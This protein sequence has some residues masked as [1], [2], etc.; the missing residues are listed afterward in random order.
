MQQF[1]RERSAIEKEYSSKLTAL[2]RKYFERKNRKQSS[3]SV[4]D[5]PTVTPGSLESASMT[6]WGVQ[7][8]TLESRAGEHDRFANELLSQLAEP[9]KALS[10]RC[11]DLRRQH[12]EFAAK[13][14]K[15][16][17]TTYG[18][19]RKSKG[20]YDSECQD[21]EKSR[22]KIDT[23]HSSQKNQ[24]T[25]QSQLAN[26]QNAKN[27]YLISLATTNKQKERYYNGY[28]PDVL[29]SMQILNETRVSKLNNVWLQAA[30][31]ETQTLHRDSELCKHLASEIPRNN[32][33]LDS[34]MFVRHNMS[35]LQDPADFT[36]EPSPIWHDD[37]D[38][39]RT[40]SAKTYLRNILAKSKQQ[41]SEQ[42]RE[43][44]VKRRDL[45]SSRRQRDAGRGDPLDATREVLAAH[46]IHHNAERQKIT[47]EVEVATIMTA[48]GDLSIGARPHPLKPQTFKIPT[49]CDLCGDRIWGLSAKG[50]DCPDC[51]FC[52]HSKCEMKVPA[53]CPGEC[54]KDEK[55]RL[56]V[57]R[58][59]AAKDKSVA[60][61]T[62]VPERSATVS[63]KPSLGRSGTV[64]SMSTLS[65]G[66]AT[67]S[68]PHLTPDGTGETETSDQLPAVAA[69]R[70]KIGGSRLKA[71]P[72]AVYKK[73]EEPDEGKQRGKM[74]YAY[75]ATG[76]GEVSVSEGDS[77]S[78]LEAD[79]GS[80]WMK[81]SSSAGEGL[82]PASYTEVAPVPS[83][84]PSHVAH[85]SLS[86]TDR[87]SQY[88]ASSVSL[89]G[90]TGAAPAKKKG[91]AVAPRRGAKKL[92][93]VE[94]MYAYEARTDAEHSMEEG[95]RFVVVN[96]DAGD[97]WAEVEKGG[98]VKAVPANYVKDV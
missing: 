20:K 64:D 96:R 84:S 57:E 80:G 30:N 42:R 43:V 17:D 40:E 85:A 91:P 37:S 28:I 65:S 41:L 50:F 15:E 38:M 56:K 36:F 70:P 77:I 13:L 55:R 78:V 75:T 54:S 24:A 68:P 3:I 66:Y 9:L 94:A 72:P 76:A 82:V 92:K 29:D 23:D 51:G 8:T 10:A 63:S 58:Q 12:A 47:T 25:H 11:E 35:Q 53:D 69:P 88:S 97:G 5:T 27:T 4:G 93:Q 46:Q 48:V 71:P 16:R 89:A 62:V 59:E 67:R 19:L 83:P 49:N 22:K 60:E 79:D 18:E 81:I 98:V 7:L 52:C 26:M 32:P 33:S 21:V 86:D 1:Y 45:D 73:W 90:S 31:L 39:A 14:E 74:L 87:H 2:A 6:T 34:M 61:D 95:D 44:D